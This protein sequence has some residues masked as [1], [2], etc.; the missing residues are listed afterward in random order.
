[1]REA[2]QLLTARCSRDGRE[3]GVF[4]VVTCLR[5]QGGI[6]NGSGSPR[7]FH[8]INIQTDHM[9]IEGDKEESIEKEVQCYWRVL[10][11][12]KTESD[13]AAA[14]DNDRTYDILLLQPCV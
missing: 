4:L 13:V 7:I 5:D 6:L 9:V 3:A 10:R 2:Y 11:H 1:M 14:G 8:H 12:D